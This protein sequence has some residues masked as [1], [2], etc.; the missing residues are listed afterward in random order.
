MAFLLSSRQLK[1]GILGF[2]LFSHGWT[3]GWWGL[4]AW[5][6]N[7]SRGS[8]WHWPAAACFYIGGAGVLLG[9]LVMVYQ[10]GHWRALQD[11]L[12]RCLDPRRLTVCWW[13]LVMLLYPGLTLLSAA[14]AIAAG[15]DGSLAL[16]HALA[17]MAHPLA[18]L[19]FLGFILL[20]GPLPEE[21]GWRGYLL[22]QLLR[23]RS[24]LGA[25]LLV[26]I[27]WWSW[28]LPL[29]YLPGYFEAFDGT[30]RGPWRQLLSLIPTAILYTWIY[31]NTRRSLL[32]VILFH[33]LGNL[34]GQLL[35]PSDAV[36]QIRWWFEAAIALTVVTRWH[37]TPP[38]TH[39]GDQ[40]K[41]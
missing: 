25:S 33:V 37:H 30:P 6:A 29:G 2:L 22:D 21:I 9:G 10:Q 32:A 4:A 24:P 17:R 7:L 34:T 12:W 18:L 13:G 38:P 15:F 26:A 16:D 35:L 40:T 23:W 27:A 8:V 14:I 28:H 39:R 36:R 31:L 41:L 20:I 11:L 1:S 19:R 5:I 3:W